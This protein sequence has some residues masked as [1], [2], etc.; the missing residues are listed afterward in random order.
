MNLVANFFFDKDRR[1]PYARA[2]GRQLWPRAAAD[3]RDAARRADAGP[4]ADDAPSPL[5]TKELALVNHG[6]PAASRRGEL[7]SILYEALAKKF[8]SYKVDNAHSEVMVKILKWVIAEGHTGHRDAFGNTA[9]ENDANLD[10]DAIVRNEVKKIGFDSSSTTS[11]PSTQG[12][13]GDS[14]EGIM[15]GY[16]SDET[17]NCMPSRTSWR[18]RK[19]LT[20]VRAIGRSGGPPRRQDPARGALKAK[21][22]EEQNGKDFRGAYK[23]PE[24]V[25]PSMADMNE[26]IHEHVVLATLKSI[27]LKNGKPATP[28]YDRRRNLHINPSGKFIIG[29]PQ[30]DAGLTGRK[31][32]IDTYGGWGA[33]GGGAFSAGPDEGRPSAAYAAPLDGQDAIDP[34]SSRPSA[35]ADKAVAANKAKILAKWVD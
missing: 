15:F 17:E 2:L 6:E 1:A 7:P 19:V 3:G 23:G 18:R 24:Q 29:G 11:A 30:G 27:T 22:T 10:Y 14:R 34:P 20:E 4:T 25:A 12:P 16:A 33:H 35:D 21:R 26:A 32:I 31:I 9:S 8:C 13:V 5:S 28:I